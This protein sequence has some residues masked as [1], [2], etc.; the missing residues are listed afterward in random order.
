MVVDYD[1]AI[2]SG[3]QFDRNLLMVR[4]H[5]GYLDYN[6]QMEIDDVQVSSHKRGWDPRSAS[7]HADSGDFHFQFGLTESP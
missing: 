7:V 5:G 6:S 1:K 2:Q 3:L 4:D